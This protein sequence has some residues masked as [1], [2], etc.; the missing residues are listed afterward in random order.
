MDITDQAYRVLRDK[1]ENEEVRYYSEIE[2]KRLFSEKL[3][4]GDLNQLLFD[5]MRQGRLYR[6]KS[7]WG[8][9]AADYESYRS[10]HEAYQLATGNI[11]EYEP[12]EKVAR[13]SEVEKADDPMEVI[14]HIMTYIGDIDGQ[15]ARRKLEEK[16]IF[17]WK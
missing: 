10:I 5:L 15:E 9:P 4:V 6:D 1:I 8:L 16:G 17:Y 12:W 3:D 11:P 7:K 14:V 13:W 2:I